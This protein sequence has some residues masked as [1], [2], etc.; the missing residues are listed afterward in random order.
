MLLPPHLR[1]KK[2]KK[3]VKVYVWM[4]LPTIVEKRTVQN[5]HL[6]YSFNVRTRNWYWLKGKIF[7]WFE[8]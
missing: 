2:K 1:L 5:E 3:K 6:Y 4:K 8:K 7:N